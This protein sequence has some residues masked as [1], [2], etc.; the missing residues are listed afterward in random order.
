[1]IMSE[2]E[3]IYDYG[4]VH[5]TF[6]DNGEVNAMYIDNLNDKE[7]PTTPLFVEKKPSERGAMYHV[8]FNKDIFIVQKDSFGRLRVVYSQINPMREF[9]SEEPMGL[10]IPLS[11]YVFVS[12]A[13][14]M[15]IGSLNNK[16]EITRIKH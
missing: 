11:A 15:Y 1:M 14:T 10:P 2:P 3:F 5:L 13:D 4:F 7:H 6:D 16:F 9:D 8:M 12:I